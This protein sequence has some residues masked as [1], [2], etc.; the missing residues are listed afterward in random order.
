MGFAII[1][2]LLSRNVLQAT[3]KLTVARLAS[4]GVPSAQNHLLKAQSSFTFPAK[5]KK[6][7]GTFYLGSLNSKQAH[8][9]VLLRIDIFKFLAR[10]CVI[11]PLEKAVQ[12]F[13]LDFYRIVTS[14]N[15]LLVSTV[16]HRTN[17]VQRNQQAE[18]FTLTLVPLAWQFIAYTGHDGHILTPCYILFDVLLSAVWSLIFGLH[19]LEILLGIYQNCPYQTWSAFKGP[20]TVMWQPSSEIQN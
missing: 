18:S 4:I 19:Q 9:W 17:P 12:C 1:A 8:C 20:K 3:K 6:K 14:A 16:G 7:R 5:K 2:I 10:R 15:V 13:F 11:A